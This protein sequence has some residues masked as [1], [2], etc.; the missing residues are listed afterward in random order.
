[1]G[2]GADN[3][4]YDEGVGMTVLNASADTLLMGEGVVWDITTPVSTDK[5]LR[6]KRA[7]ADATAEFAGVLSRNI[8]PSTY[9]PMIHTGK[10]RARVA[11]DVTAGAV[12]VSDFVT[13]AAGRLKLRVPGD[14]AAAALAIDAATQ[15]PAGSGSYWADVILPGLNAAAVQS[16]L[17]GALFN[18][19]SM[20]LSFLGANSATFIRGAIRVPAAGSI[21]AVHLL[22]NTTIAA[23]SGGTN[24]YGFQIRRMLAN[25]GPIISVTPVADIFDATGYIGGLVADTLFTLTPAFLQTAN[26]VVARNELLEVVVTETG[27]GADLSAAQLNVWLEM[28][29]GAAVPLMFSR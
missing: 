23:A 29:T 24:C 6:V 21:T 14:Y 10:V 4:G 18:S 19:N 17:R 16:A 15:E 22:S 20:T 9:G 2:A 5:A 1:M 7:T 25:T 26:I 12:V 3:A 27:T 11:S 13:G 28:D 8:A